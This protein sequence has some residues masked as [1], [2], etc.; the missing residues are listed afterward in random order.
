MKQEP[1]PVLP[2]WV[3]T[4]LAWVVSQI[5]ILVPSFAP[6]TQV[7][8]QGGTALIAVGVLLAHALH[9]RAHGEVTAAR[10]AT[11][12]TVNAAAPTITPT[13]PYPPAQVLR[14]QVR[15]LGGE[16]VA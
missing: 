2:V 16:P 3:G 8:L 11:P 12:V 1:L 5:V 15:L 14:D 6:F 4:G 7:A 10:V 9:I 13:Q